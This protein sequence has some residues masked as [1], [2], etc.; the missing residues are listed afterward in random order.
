MLFC[1]EEHGACVFLNASHTDFEF[2][3]VCFFPFIPRRIA[4]SSFDPA[5]KRKA[6]SLRSSSLRTSAAQIEATEEQNESTEHN[7]ED[8][9]NQVED[10]KEVSLGRHFFGES[11]RIGTAYTVNIPEI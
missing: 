1:G 7:T 4:S 2:F 10:K 5:L 8:N 11:R 9:N 3:F 6:Q